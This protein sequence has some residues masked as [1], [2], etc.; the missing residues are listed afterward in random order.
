MKEIEPMSPEEAARRRRRS[1]AIG[2]A[3]AVVVVL[4][5][6]TTFVRLSQNVAG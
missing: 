2:V 5:Y 1:I 3:L 4:F 6:I